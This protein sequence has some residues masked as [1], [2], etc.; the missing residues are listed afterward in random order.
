[1][2]RNEL[3]TATR[4][5]L[6]RLLANGHSIAPEALDDSEYKGISL[7]LPPL[8]ERLSWKV[9]KKAFHRDPATGRLRGWNV[10]LEQ[11]GVDAPARDR[12]KNGRRVTFGHF[13]VRPAGADAPRAL[14]QSLVL[15]YALG[16]NAPLA[17][18]A[19]VRDLLVC[20][21]P[22]KFDILFGWML[23]QLGP[24]RIPTPSYFLLERDAPL[25]DVV[26]P[27]GRRTQ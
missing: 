9:F 16:E 6:R 11:D 24:A 3:L 12:L 7:G 5:E 19:C 14:T 21:E 20:P 2:N 10:R 4:S 26:L 15:D 17:P 27:P 25:A 8:V 18:T 23:L 1:M 22:G 13:D